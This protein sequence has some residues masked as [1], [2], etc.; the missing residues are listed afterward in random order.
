MVLIHSSNLSRGFC[1]QK[2]EHRTPAVKE[3]NS[4]M[5]IQIINKP[6]RKGGEGALALGGSGSSLF[7]NIACNSKD[8]VKDARCMTLV[9][10]RRQEH[11]IFVLGKGMSTKMEHSCIFKFNSSYVKENRKYVI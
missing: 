4:I 9:V 6:F 2:T 7:G 10:E 8:N 1:A 11:S 3:C 5:L